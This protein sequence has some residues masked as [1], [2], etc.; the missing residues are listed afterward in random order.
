MICR[1]EQYV[2]SNTILKFP[3][4]IKTLSKCI[5]DENLDLTIFLD[6]GLK[7]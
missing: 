2:H 4:I 5:P 3:L 7:T 1:C 6:Y